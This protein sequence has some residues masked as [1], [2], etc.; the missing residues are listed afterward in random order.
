MGVG[1]VSA[2]VFWLEAPAALSGQFYSSKATRLG[3]SQSDSLRR[4]SQPL[5]P[6]LCFEYE[7]VCDDDLATSNANIKV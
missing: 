2:T 1:A 3:D 7:T 4:M 6:M 5:L